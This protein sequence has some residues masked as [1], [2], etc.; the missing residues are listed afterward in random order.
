MSCQTNLIYLIRLQVWGDNCVDI[1][2]F[3]FCKAFDFIPHD[4]ITKILV[5]YTFTEAYLKCIKNKVTD[6]TQKVVV[7]RDSLLNV[8]IFQCN[9]AGISQNPHVI[10]HFWQWNGSKYKIISDKISGWHKDWWSGNEGSR[11]QCSWLI[12]PTE[13]KFQNS[14]QSN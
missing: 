14:F 1:I 2:Y 11:I 7:N 4:I 10:H 5:L 12:V 13:T 8:N 6:R 3:N 9:S